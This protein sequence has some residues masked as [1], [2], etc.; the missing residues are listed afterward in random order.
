VATTILSEGTFDRG[1]YAAELDAALGNLDDGTRLWFENDRIR[2]WEV[3]LQP[4]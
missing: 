4:G 1:D 3:R 2:V